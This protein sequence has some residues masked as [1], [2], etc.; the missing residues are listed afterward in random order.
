M[1]EK[2]VKIY[3]VF[4]EYTTKA[5]MD[6]R[7]DDMRDRLKNGYGS[8]AEKEFN[9]E[10]EAKAYLQ[11]LDDADGWLAAAQIDSDDV[12]QVKAIMEEI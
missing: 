6:G 11:G 9:T 5:Y 12:E 7:I 10:A 4:G 8:L 2:K 1:N 3:V